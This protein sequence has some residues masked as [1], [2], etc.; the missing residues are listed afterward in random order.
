VLSAVPL[1][2]VDRLMHDASPYGMM[3]LCRSIALEW[4]VALA[5]ILARQ[6]F[7]PPIDIQ[8]IQQDY[9]KL[10]TSAAQRLLRFWQSRQAGP[11]LPKTQ[12]P[13]RP[14]AS[15]PPAA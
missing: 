9:H 6:G 13:A 4:R 12:Q 10:S 5:V 7:G 1:D 3:V 14:A 2:L 8:E 15:P 11:A